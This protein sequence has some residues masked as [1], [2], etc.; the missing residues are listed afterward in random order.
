ME[1]LEYKQ[2]L[3]HIKQGLGDLDSRN[4]VDTVFALGK[5]H[6]RHY[7]ES[8]SHQLQPLFGKLVQ[9]MIAQADERVSQ[10]KEPMELAYLVK[11]IANLSKVVR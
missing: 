5:M 4:F 11:G 9:S 6:K 7:P 3:W 2:I 8:D 1:T 10:I